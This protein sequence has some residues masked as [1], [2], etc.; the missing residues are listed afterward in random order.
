MGIVPWD[1]M[2]VEVGLLAIPDRDRVG[3]SGIICCWYLDVLLLF[4]LL[5]L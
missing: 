4:Y 1:G 5:V 2:M 3:G